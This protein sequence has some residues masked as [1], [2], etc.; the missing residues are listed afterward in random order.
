MKTLL[1]RRR[2]LVLLVM[3]LL[4]LL[5]WRP[6]ANRLRSRL[7]HSISSALGRPVEIGS[8]HLQVLPRP[9]F[10]LSH[11]VVYDDPQSGAEPVLRA[12]E[13]TAWLHLSSIWRGR[14][15]FARL[16]LT[17]PSFNL[18]R[19]DDGHWNLEPILERAAQTPVAPT[20]LGRSEARP[21][22]PYIEA[23]NGRINFKVGAEKKSFAFTEADFALWLESENQW[24]MR[25]KARPVRTDMSLSD[26]GTFR[27]SGTWNRGQDWR[28]SPLQMNA[29]LQGAQL[30]QLSKLVGGNDKG[31]RGTVDA[32][33]NITGALPD[34]K[35][36]ISASVA[37]FRRYDIIAGSST[38]LQANCD[39]RYANSE[40]RFSEISCTLPLSQGR[41]ELTGDARQLSAAWAYQL[42][43]IASNV[44]AQAAVD[45]VHRVKQR[46]PEDLTASGVIQADFHLQHDPDSPPSWTGNGQVDA[47]TLRSATLRNELTVGNIPLQL[48][49]PIRGGKA[50]RQHREPAD[51]PQEHYFEVGPFALDLSDNV[52]ELLA[53]GK[54]SSTT[55]RASLEKESP[56]ASSAQAHAWFTASGYAAALSGSAPLQRVLEFART[57]GFDPPQIALAGSSQFDLTARGSWAGFAPPR[58]NG[59]IQLKAAR[60]EF[61]GINAPVE[62]ASASVILTPDQLKI[63]NVSASAG[64][65]HWTGNFSRPRNCPPAGC[66]IQADIQAADVSSA[67]LNELLNP[68]IH[69]QSWY[70][71]LT[72]SPVSSN[73]M[74][75]GLQVN[76]T[77]GAARFV[78]HGLV[79]SHVESKF[80]LDRGQLHLVNLTASLLGGQ[81]RG[82]WDLDFR[83]PS[84]RYSGSG[85]LQH[86]AMKQ[87]GSLMHEDWITGTGG[88]LYQ[89][90]FRGL[91]SA[92]MLASARG[93]LDFD[94]ATGALT[95][96]HLTGE[97]PLSF[98]RFRGLLALKD[99]AFTLSQGKLESPQ[100]IFAVSGIASFG[101][102]LDLKF[103]RKGA[104]VFAVSGTLAEPHVEPVESKAQVQLQR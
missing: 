69:K 93:T 88:A 3:A 95:R 91:S 38:R 62:I 44:P 21:R 39:A 11:F 22:F 103:E 40:H 4:A 49:S 26:T 20:G 15:E 10:E 54:L 85:S 6:G 82:N 8:V 27:I 19:R 71:I 50:T 83:S 58:A 48:H 60:A 70:R 14:F 51:T 101:R 98:R 87:L 79:A 30:G 77:L 96:L 42:H 25:L 47:L 46:I 33:M 43:L 57:S 84:P 52:S 41:L 61:R 37:D 28:S 24:G 32:T 66:V 9:G 65:L 56:K 92:D 35:I 89:L 80:A 68:G 17:E 72:G 81:Q 13:V 55:S 102:R 36:Q 1:I 7:T 90:D 94:C 59:S 12:E 16:R 104:P 29:R 99:G 5:L 86:S 73:S 2:W 78:T 31:W 64:K 67:M 74:L 34:L 18:T 97:A 76:G 63:S 75:S 53:T 23:S 100:G 45:L